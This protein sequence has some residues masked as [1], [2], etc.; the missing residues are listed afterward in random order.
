MA[1]ECLEDD[2]TIVDAS[3][4]WRRIHPGW[5]VPDEN[6]GGMRASSA[7][8]DNSPDGSPT[9]V[10]LADI[11]RGTGRTPG[12]VIAEFDGYALSSITAGQARGCK[13]GIARDPLPSEPAHAHVFGRK[14]KA[15]KRCLAGHARWVIEPAEA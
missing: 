10:L 7:A 13:Q 9:S 1:S 5:V 14:T 11:V 3:E 4:L 15:A 8:F 6:T 12:D 2:A